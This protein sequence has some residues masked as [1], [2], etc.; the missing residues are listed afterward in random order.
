MKIVYGMKNFV[1]YIFNTWGII[2]WRVGNPR[3]SILLEPR[4]D[5]SHDPR[6]GTNRDS[7]KVVL[8]T[9]LNADQI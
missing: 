6:A 2:R 3:G 9:L 4:K 1:N 7:L 5:T 8:H